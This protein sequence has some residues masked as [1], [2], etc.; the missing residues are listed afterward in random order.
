[1]T[2]VAVRAVGAGALPEV[3]ARLVELLVDSV[4]HGASIGFLEP[5]SEAEADAYWQRVEAA[6]AG[7]RCLLFVA[8]TTDGT[9][10][11]TVQLDIDTF[12]NQEHRGTVCKLLVDTALRRQGIGEALMLELERTAA[13]SGRWLLTLDT[14]TPAAV[15][16]YERLGWSS[17]GSIPDYA[18]NPDRS[19][20]QTTFYW[21]QLPLH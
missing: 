14:A 4:R 20:T 2:T 15:R 6:V 11:G 17:S 3:R 21:K 7:R 12:P 16:L 9:L 13:A 19:L 18:M 5:L 8:E 1:M 10:A